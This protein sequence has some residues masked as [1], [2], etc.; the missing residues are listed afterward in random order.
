MNENLGPGRQKMLSMSIDSLS[1]ADSISPRDDE[2]TYLLGLAHL[3]A[4]NLTRAAV[5]FKT[6]YQDGGEY[7]SR[8]LTSLQE[9]YKLPGHRSAMSFQTFLDDVNLSVQSMHQ[10]SPPSTITKLSEYAGSAACKDCHAEVYRSWSETGMAKM[11]R[12]YQPQNVIGDF[13][14]NNEFYTGDDVQYLHGKLNVVPGAEHK[15]FAR[16]VVRS[17]R[18]YFDIHQSDGRWHSYPVDYTI[19][20]KWQ[21]AYATKLP[22]GQIHVFPIQYSVVEKKWLNYW[23]S[24][25]GPGTERSDP[26]NFER[27]D[28]ST[29][30]QEKCAVCHTS[31]LRNTK[32][33]GLEAD[34]L[35]FREAGIGCEM[36][37]GPSANHIA[38]MTRG[39][40]YDKAALD[41]PVDFR[42]TSS[43]Q[44]VSIC[45]QCHMQARIRDPGPDGELNY[46]TSGQ[47]F[48]QTLSVPFGEF[49]RKGFYKDGRFSQTTFIVE[50]LQRSKCYRDGHLTCGTCHD[51]HGHGFSANQTSLRYKDEPDKMCTGC[52]TQFQDKA[53]IEIHTHHAS[54][55]EASQCVSCHMPRIMDALTFSARTHQ[56]DDIPNAEM[57]MRFGQEDSPNACLLCHK[58]K[59]LQWMQGQLQS[60]NTT[61]Q[62]VSGTAMK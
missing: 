37:H 49:T 28:N 43:N 38:A 12:A 44:F 10:D 40:F 31:Q 26:Y 20:S 25:D 42:K 30:Y 51:P 9:I 33:G 19:G 50:A 29:S 15:L 21:Q 47:F 41:P 57:T 39:E 1:K 27:L 58:E 7:A 3:A 56:I 32:G 59:S 23:R 17:G 4:G 18:H 24:L 13:L 8:A 55:S 2:I 62:V 6:V 60:W 14:K 11:L 35:V 5:A 22:N 61:A 52:H 36:C 53:K 34:G 45:A 48:Q 54:N 16:M 46:S